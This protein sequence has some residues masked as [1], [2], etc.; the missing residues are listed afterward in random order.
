[1]K[2]LVCYK[3]NVNKEYHTTIRMTIPKTWMNQCMI[4][5]IMKQ[6]LDAYNIAF[7]N[8]L[9][10]TD[11]HFAMHW[12]DNITYIRISYDGII[13]NCIQDRATL[14]VRHNCHLKH[15]KIHSSPLIKNPT[16]TVADT[17]HDIPVSDGCNIKSTN[18]VV[19]SLPHT[20]A[21][22][23]NITT[24]PDTE[25]T[26]TS[27]LPLL[28]LSTTEL[29][30]KNDDL[31]Q[32]VDGKEVNETNLIDNPS[33][34]IKS[35]TIANHDIPTSRYS[36][37]AMMK[38]N[39][40]TNPD[41]EVTS[42]TLLPLSTTLKV[43]ESNI[44][45]DDKLIYRDVDVHQVLS[46][47]YHH[48]ITIPH[49][50]F[51]TT[52]TCH[53]DNKM[54]D[55]DEHSIIKGRD[56]VIIEN[57]TKEKQEEVTIEN[58]TEEKQ[59]VIAENGISKQQ[60]EV[61]E[62]GTNQQKEVTENDT[63]EQQELIENGTKVKQEELIE[64]VNKEKKEVIECGIKEK[65]DVIIDK[66]DTKGNDIMT[67]V[68]TVSSN[69]MNEMATTMNMETNINI[70][71]YDTNHSDLQHEVILHCIEEQEEVIGTNN[72]KGNDIMTSLP[73][74]NSNDIN[75]TAMTSNMEI[76]N[77]ANNSD[78]QADDNNTNRSSDVSMSSSSNKEDSVVDHFRSILD[79]LGVPSNTYQTVVK[80]LEDELK[81]DQK[82]DNNNPKKNVVT[83]QLGRMLEEGY[84]NAM[85]SVAS[86]KSSITAPSTSL[87]LTTITDSER[88]PTTTLKEKQVPNNNTKHN[89]HKQHIDCEGAREEFESTLMEQ[90]EPDITD[91]NIV[92]QDQ[93][94]NIDYDSS[95]EEFELIMNQHVSKNGSCRHNN[96]TVVV[97]H[98]HDK[99]KDKHRH[100][101]TSTYTSQEYSTTAK[102]GTNHVTITMIQQCA[103][104]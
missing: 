77:I 78:I 52:E 98:R 48:D 38:T 102:D 97:N 63:K 66:N 87:P 68:Q 37:T 67:S 60:E 94:H 32:T 6:F 51:C 42:T 13:S 69:D 15:N 76:N 10:E 34:L 55:N 101:R 49:I 62:N 17:T 61:I 96:P 23:T 40:N 3:D 39:T 5:D 9:N 100:S 50:I 56:E 45:D 72:V 86:I 57:C 41:M 53:I 22:K 54:T 80:D 14:Y 16:I 65:Q 85:T 104:E 91:H 83:L 31:I 90:L 20:T 103:S 43:V 75:T 73:A 74:V 89:N 28:P 24:N 81:S 26:T 2:I 84:V 33:P 11:L 8:Q 19:S 30:I 46:D 21:M 70:N 79:W 36:S 4:L 58:G 82:K 7:T 25:V 35:K 99:K 29:V 47:D 59:E 1:M 27:L 44:I 71:T 64:N 12:V 95:G 92:N 18:D 93:H 88:E